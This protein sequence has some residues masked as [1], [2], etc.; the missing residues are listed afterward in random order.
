M[1]LVVGLAFFG[2][3]YSFGVFFT[4]IQSEFGLSRASTSGVFGAYM[5]MGAVFA[6]VGG[7]ALDRYGPRSVLA[8]MGVMVGGALWWFSRL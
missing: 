5:M 8:A 3:T 6:I 2:I 4:S 7:W 1:C